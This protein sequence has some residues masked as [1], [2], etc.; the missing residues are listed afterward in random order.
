MPQLISTIVF[1]LFCS[2]AAAGDVEFRRAYVD[3]QYGQLH[4]LTA[5]PTDGQATAPAMVCFAPN[6]AAG[7]YYRLFMAELARDRV[8][9]AP[10]YPGLGQSDPPAEKMD[11]AGYAASMAEVLDALGYGDD[12][13]GRVDACGYHTGAMVAIELAVARPDLVGGVVLAGIP[14]Y[15]ADARVLQYEKN[16]VAKDLKDDFD[17]LRGSWEFTVSN[18]QEGVA[19]ERGYDNFVDL[20]MQRYI[21]HYAYHAVFTYAAEER[22]PHIEQPVLILNTHG[23]LKEETRTIAPLFPNAQLIEI[24]ELHHGVFD[25]GAGLLANHIRGWKR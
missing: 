16:V 20:L 18:R 13:L 7:R 11:M 8:V 25:V 17:G 15:D 19:L 1:F 2:T 5:T 12:G 14:Y 10:D 4:V 24:P 9:I 3:G 22:V 6:P 23:S 21:T